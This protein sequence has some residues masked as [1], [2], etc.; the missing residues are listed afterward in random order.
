ML[1]G[2]RIIVIEDEKDINELIAYNLREKGFYVEQT[3]DGF[4][5][6]ERLA[7][8]YFDI[9][10]LD[11]MLPGMDG[12]DICKEFKDAGVYS[13]A[14]FIIVSA[15]NSV[16]DKIYA[17]ILGVD[18]YFSKPFD[19]NMLVGAVQEINAMQNKEFKVNVN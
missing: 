9:V 3:Y 5:A 13:K 1:N 2:K 15:K 19:I 7:N 10:I 11:I 16:Y 17:H 8:S 14:F 12:F 18:R 6:K 4:E